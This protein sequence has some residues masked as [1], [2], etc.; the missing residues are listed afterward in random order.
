MRRPIIARFTRHAPEPIQVAELHRLH[1]THTAFPAGT[2]PEI[3][4]ISETLP[5]EPRAAVARFDELAEAA[6]IV[7]VVMPINLLEAII[8]FSRFVQ[9]NGLLVRAVTERT[10]HA[11]GTATFAFSHYEQVV[12]VDIVTRRV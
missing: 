4:M 8:K 5:S 3:I 11:D 9:Q 12:K 6:Q 1:A 7:E 2:M 10:M